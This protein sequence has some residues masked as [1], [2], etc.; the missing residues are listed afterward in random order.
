M[1]SNHSETS[2]I[3]I[4]NDTGFAQIRSLVLFLFVLCAL[5]GSTFA[6]DFKIVRE[7]VEHAALTRTF[8]GKPVNINL[9]RLDL[10]KVRLDVHRANDAAIG[11]ETTSSIA[12]RHRGVAA[13]N[14]GFFRLDRS[15]FLGDPVGMLMI[16]GDLISRVGTV[17]RRP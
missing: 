14:A 16:D 5:C 11:T 8:S 7:G 2:H 17:R 10:R 4:V 6:Q 12:E 1:I 3:Q 15:R 9:L 13:V